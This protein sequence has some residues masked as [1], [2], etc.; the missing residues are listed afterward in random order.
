MFER[1]KKT[2]AFVLI[3]KPAGTRTAYYTKHIAYTYMM[4]VF[5]YS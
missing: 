3:K 4:F 5:T 1:D 2:A